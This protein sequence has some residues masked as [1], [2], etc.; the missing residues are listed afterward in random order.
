MKQI[1]IVTANTPGLVAEVSR[2]LAERSINIDT[3]D[4]EVAGEHAVIILVV[5]RYDSALAT[6][7]DAGFPAVSEDA[8]VVRIRDEPGALAKIAQ[9]LRDA[10]IELRSLRILKR[11]GGWGLVALSTDARDEAREVVKDILVSRFGDETPPLR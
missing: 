4:A 9:R 6:L 5:D 10:R 8:I 2:V 11:A 1:T 3:I 7:R